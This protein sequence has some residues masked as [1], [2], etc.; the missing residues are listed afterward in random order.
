MAERAD[1]EDRWNFM[2]EDSTMFLRVNAAVK[3]MLMSANAAILG[4]I[5]GDV[6]WSYYSR[7]SVSA[8]RL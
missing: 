3:A 2:S 1:E 5:F 8:V 4:N 7:R 6:L